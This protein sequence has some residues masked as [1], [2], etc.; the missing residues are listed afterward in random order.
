MRS[1]H[2]DDVIKACGL[3]KGAVGQGG[4]TRRRCGRGFC[5]VKANGELVG[6]PSIRNRL[7]KLAAPP[8]WR[9]V[10]YAAST[11]AH[12]QAVGYDQSGRRQYIYHED[13]IKR[14]DK[15]KFHRMSVFGTALPRLRRRARVA[16]RS[17]DLHEMSCGVVA[18]LLDKAALRI[19]SAEYAKQNGVF[20]A[21]SLLKRHVTLDEDRIILDFRAKGG[22]RR[23][24]EL[25]DQALCEALAALDDQPGRELFRISDEKSSRILTSCDVNAWIHDIAGREFSA[26]DFRTF[27]AS[28]LFL[29][30]LF[31]KGEAP[32]SKRGRSSIL[33]AAYECVA[34]QLGNTAA[35]CKSSYCPPAFASAWESGG[36]R[37]INR[38]ARRCRLQLPLR[39]KRAV[40]AFRRFYGSVRSERSR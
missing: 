28:S 34:E 35:I 11:S 27:R 4:Y 33:S 39:D 12:I 15:L 14:R 8:A 10:W 22:K 23:H 32:Q 25:N 16:L 20:G 18:I 3:T 40:C 38:A 7:K 2:E 36:I 24:V 13:W 19:G 26:K 29:D 31:R 1:S 17:E 6:D 21:S 30:A 5:Y 9:D 37:A